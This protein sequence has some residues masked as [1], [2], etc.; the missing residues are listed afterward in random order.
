MLRHPSLFS[1]LICPILLTILWGLAVL[2]FG[3]A[4]LLKLQ[5]HALIAVKCPAAVAWYKRASVFSIE[6]I[7]YTENTTYDSTCSICRIVCVIFVL[8]E[9]AVLS[10]LFYLIILPIYQDGLFDRVLK[11]RGLKHV[12]KQ[13]EGNDLVKCMRGV[14][15]GLWILL[16]QI[17]VLIITLPFNIVPVLGQMAFVTINGW[18]LTFGLRFHYDAEIR[19]IS[20]LQSRREAWQRRSEYSGFGA[21][22][23]ALE[24]IPIANLLFVWTNIVGCALWVADEIEREELRLQQ[25]QS[26]HSLMA[27]QGS[28]NHGSQYKMAASAY[29]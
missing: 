18:V 1:N 15:G 12:L 28:F 8:L 3:F 4:Y 20:V 22:A 26:T 27:G 19:N 7:Y 6:Y 24:M 10:I 14:S 16:F 5:A 2:I 21:V 25:E 29:P 9:V 11:L 13:N 17:L 23:V